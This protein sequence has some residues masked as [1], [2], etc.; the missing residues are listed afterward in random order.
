LAAPSRQAEPLAAATA[1]PLPKID[2][3]SLTLPGIVEPYESVPVSAKLTATIVSMKVR[4]GSTVAKGQLLC[5]LDDVELRR[6]ID[7]AQLAVMQAEEVL[8]RSREER[9]SEQ[10]RETLALATAE[11]EMESCRTESQLRVQQAEAARKRAERELADQRAL[12]EAKAVSADQVRAKQEAVEDA[13]RLLEQTQAAVDAGLASRTKAVEQAQLDVR[14]ER[15]SKQDIA[16]YE[17]AEANARA[18]LAERERRL[19]DLRVVAPVGGTVRIIARTRTSA[20]MATGQSAEVLGP[21]VRVYEGDPFLEIATTERSCVRIE[22]DETDI[23]RIHVGMKA[24]ITGDAF[25]GRELEGEVAEIQISGRTAGRG[26]TL[27]PV[28]V[29][30][31]APLKDVRMG[32]TA[33]VTIKLSPSD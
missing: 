32:M 28:T 9:G 18:E 6:Q 2:R 23:G 7:A 19:A 10:E 5:A 26:V 31:T 21:G 22:V 1:T 30:I 29:R 24:R 16:A 12:H 17:L 11:R 15:V 27:F 20:M 13:A 8:R 4:D 25:A 3:D 14:V 33:D